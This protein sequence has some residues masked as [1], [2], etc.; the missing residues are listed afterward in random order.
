MSATH[1]TYY[2][3][4][5]PDRQDFVSV[6]SDIN[7]NMDKIDAAIHGVDTGKVDKTEKGVAN[8]VASLDASGKVPSSQL[9]SYVDDVIE[10][11]LYNGQFYKESSHTTLITPEEDKIYVD[12]P[13][14][15]SYRWSGSLYVKIDDPKEIIDDNAGSGDTD[16]VWS[17]NKVTEE[18]A[19]QNEVVTESLESKADIITVTDN[20]PASVKTFQ[21]GAD[22]L[23]MALTV[24]IEPVQDL[25]GYG[26]PW[27]AGG[28]KNLLPSLLSNIKRNN[29]VGTWDDDEYSVNGITFK[30][31]TNSEGYVTS[32]NVS[33]TVTSGTPT[34]RIYADDTG[35]PAGSY[36]VNGCPSTG[37]NDTYFLRLYNKNAN[38]GGTALIDS[39]SGVTVDNTYTIKRV[40]ISV[41]NGV[42]LPSGGVVFKPMI[43]LATESDG[44]FAPYSNICPISGWTGANVSRTGKNLFND[45]LAQGSIRTTSGE[46]TNNATRVRTANGTL[47]KPGTYT[48]SCN[49]AYK[50]NAFF[51]KPDGTFIE[52]LDSSNMSVLPYTFTLAEDTLCK[53]VFAL[54]DDGN[55]L[56]A[57][58][59]NIQVE[60]GSVASSYTAYA[61]HTYPITFPQSA[62]T[63]YGGT[64]TV[65]RD[66]TGTLIADKG[67]TVLDG[68]ETVAKG[69]GLKNY[70]RNVEDGS[71]AGRTEAGW[72]SQAQLEQIHLMCNLTKV[73]A[74]TDDSYIHASA[75]CGGG[76]TVFQP[77]IFLP[78]CET[79]AAAQAWL[80]EQATAGHPLTWCYLLK[81]PV[82]YTLTAEQVKSLLGVNNILADTGNILSV[83]YPADTKLYVDQQIADKISASQRL[84]ELIVTANHE[85]EMKA[86]KAYSKDELLIV[87]GTLYKA[88]TSIA[89]GATL[90]VNTNVTATTVA[91]ELAALA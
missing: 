18:F 86:T 66:G 51:Y 52:P 56:P 21:D 85:D 81:E 44:S 84:M 37:G 41:N 19:L 90:T 20:T 59:T 39:G 7:D 67:Y 33:G 82:T 73:E 40:N 80:Q 72:F 8:G 5:K 30:F 3:L 35:I 31:E 69:S 91:A 28:G 29:T 36:I 60:K 11:Y 79:A 70:Y 27:P 17:A 25:H 32:V 68:S 53:F 43:R 12:I 26:N 87:N 50:G 63:V 88:S 57:D 78:T 16:K 83:D 65:N 76:G 77:R 13:T 45:T 49:G 1:T 55:I 4:N 47:L 42:A 58:V 34:I 48:V 75:Y 74:S 71:I 15:S 9:P 2:N 6:V 14:S 22:N 64:L 24:G 23:P 89:N 61:G 10:G 38:S 46:S 54:S 62:G